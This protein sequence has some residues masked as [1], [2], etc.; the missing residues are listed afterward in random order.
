MSQGTLTIT[1]GAALDAVDVNIGD[2]S[3]GPNGGAGSGTAQIESGGSLTTTGTYN[4]IGAGGSDQVTVDG[5]GSKWASGG[6]LDIGG[7]GSGTLTVS[8][9]GEVEAS[10]VIVGDNYQGPATGGGSGTLT[11]ESG[12]KVVTDGQDD[13]VIGN[14]SGATGT[15][16]VDGPGSQWKS[17]SVIVVGEAGT[18]KLT[19]VSGGEVDVK[20][21]IDV[22]TGT[23]S[24]A[25]GKR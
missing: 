24:G 10:V 23:G 16:S 18:G 25:T 15:V 9:A 6:T 22:G 7:L 13:D 21:D 4:S 8:D 5:S 12:G 19:I 3:G 14:N 11:I 1:S 17:S 20:A 2:N